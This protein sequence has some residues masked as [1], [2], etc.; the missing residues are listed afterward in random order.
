M[1][2]GEI[3]QTWGKYPRKVLNPPDKSVLN[4]V[5]I[6]SVLAILNLLF[7]ATTRLWAHESFPLDSYFYKSPRLTDFFR[8]YDFWTNSNI[9]G[10]KVYQTQTSSLDPL[11]MWNFTHFPFTQ[12][13][14]R[15]AAA[16]T[17][18]A[19]AFISLNIS[20]WFL[21]RSV[22]ALW[23][24]ICMITCST[25]TYASQFTLERGNIEFASLLFASISFYFWPKNPKI[26][27]L[28]LVLAA[29]VK[30]WIGILFLLFVKRREWCAIASA[31]SF[32]VVLVFTVPI[33]IRISN[34]I[35]LSGF[36]NFSSA[37]DV[38]GHYNSTYIYNHRGVPYGNSFYGF[39]NIHSF[40]KTTNSSSMVPL[41]RRT[42]SPWFL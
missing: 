19:V 31:I 42:L 33:V 4:F 39:I 40:S 26:S 24:N 27:A 7:Y 17:Y 41:K 21:L 12:I 23:R 8:N 2:A 36:V 11:P 6:I 9:V 14:N 34:H 13:T 25:F 32:Y 29:S 30:P 3:V 10:A 1:T 28:F 20:I 16:I 18:C 15:T 35:P 22:T 37:S 5:L 38:Q